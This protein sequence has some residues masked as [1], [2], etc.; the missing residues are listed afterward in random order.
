MRLL[1]AGLWK[2]WGCLHALAEVP[3]S[4]IPYKVAR[5]ILELMEVRLT[6]HEKYAISSDTGCTISYMDAAGT[7]HTLMEVPARTQREFVCVSPRT[8][9]SDDNAVLVAVPQGGQVASKPSSAFNAVH[10][11]LTGTDSCNAAWFKLHSKYNPGGE[12]LEVRVAARPATRGDV[13]TAPIFLA[14]WY[15]APNGNAQYL[16]TSYDAASFVAG[17]TYV[18]HFSGI[19]LPAN[20]ILRFCAVATREENWSTNC[21]MGVRSHART[22]DDT[23]SFASLSSAVAT[24]VDCTFVTTFT[25]ADAAGLC[26]LLAHKE[27]LLALLTEQ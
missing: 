17:G 1:P 11:T 10:K 9:V 14:I 15:D 19:N 5:G 18:W 3:D 25:E 12:L 4:H 21:V 6:P 8:I 26:E 7:E 22:S 27:E 24:V 20:T 2:R 13:T 23:T 16:G